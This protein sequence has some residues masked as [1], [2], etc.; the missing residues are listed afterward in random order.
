M[1]A[2]TILEASPQMN[3]ANTKAAILQDFIELL[4]WNIPENTQLEYPVKAFGQTYNVDYALILEGTPAAFLEAK[5]ADKS[6]TADHE[7]QLSSYMMNMNVNYGI[8][9]NG[10]EYRFFQRQV[11]ANNVSVQRIAVVDLESLVDRAAV[12]EAYT[13]EAIETGDAG[14]IL[15]RINALREARNV[16][17]SK[18]DELA[19]KLTDV[20]SSSVTEAVTPLAESQFKEAIDRIVDEIEQEIDFE[21][22]GPTGGDA[23]ETTITPRKDLI[24]GTI[25]RGEIEGDS[26][27]R[28]AVFPSKPSGIP[29]MM[30]NN[31][32]GF[33]RVGKEFDYVAM[34]ISGEGAEV[35]YFAEV[36][37]VVRPEDA[38][39]ER[40]A[41]EY[42]D[43]D[44][45]GEGKMV[46]RFQPESLFELEDPV[47]RETK[48]PMSLQYT[49]LQALRTA[50]TTDD[51]L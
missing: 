15:G 11:D 6:L 9:S 34:Y 3:E 31:A 38:N 32:W 48:F 18:K 5:G 51:M 47:P 12:L 1:N 36:K 2:N 43:R 44:E 24:A 7:E 42:V 25:R 30:E 46:V 35:R 20:L 19:L 4:N 27:A 13:V 22:S 21:G 45:I 29:F 17:Q 39:L 49:T 10:K 14:K 40:P 8:L 37:D 16:L 23:G 33:V 50:E 26:D 41:L 28:V